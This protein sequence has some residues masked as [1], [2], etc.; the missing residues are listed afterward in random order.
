MVQD[1]QSVDR[2]WRVPKTASH[3]LAVLPLSAS[4]RRAAAAIRAGRSR[5]GQ[6]P[7]VLV[8][9]LAGLTLSGMVDLAHAAARP[10]QFLRACRLPEAEPAR[11]LPPSPR[12]GQE[13]DEGDDD[14]SADAPDDGAVSGGFNLPGLATCVR[15]SG[16]VNAGLQRDWYRTGKTTKVVGLA[17]PSAT[18]FPLSASFRIE[19]SQQL[20]DGTSL[21]TAFELQTDAA[22]DGSQETTLS[23]ASITLGSWQFGYVSSRFDYWTGDDFAFLGRIPSRS[24]GM[25]AFTGALSDET[26]VSVSLEDTRMGQSSLPVASRRF[27]DG[28]VRLLYETDALAVQ[29]AAALHEMPSASG[30]STRFGR[31]GLLGLTWTPKIQEH[32]IRISGQIAGAIDAPVYIGSQLDRRTVLPGLLPDEPTRG[33]SAVI[34]IGWDWVSDWSS[35]IYVS[36]YRLSL[37]GSGLSASVGIDRA[38]ANLVW[39]PLEGLRLG[40]ELSIAS[41]RANLSGRTAAIAFTGQQTSAQIFLERSF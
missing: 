39:K 26:T 20:A 27:P 21:L 41:Q 2:K 6:R 4:D 13:K 22:A 18:S 9:L 34:S 37:P 19:S 35:N 1:G 24:V 30:A 32:E 25:L 16:T 8:S 29:A 10:P 38:T 11:L 12:A 36:R 17:P 28:V 5:S 14:A 3:R 31:A 23:E 7:G 15:V 33:W 40:A